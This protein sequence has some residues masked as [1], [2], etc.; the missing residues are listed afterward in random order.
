[1]VILENIIRQELSKAFLMCEIKIDIDD[2]KKRGFA[3]QVGQMYADAL[4][5]YHPVSI[6]GKVGAMGEEYEKIIN[7]IGIHGY[8]SSGYDGSYFVITLE[9]GD[10]IEVF[11]NTS[12]A[13]AYIILN[14]QI[15]TIIKDPNE[16][17]RQSLPVLVN[18]Y[19][20]DYVLAGNKVENK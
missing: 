9:N 17:F 5:A 10:V 6:T 1:M 16:L 3:T 19:Y 2:L 20:S 4:K 11:R 14:G 18:K 8:L 7:K 13:Y 12:P 15:L